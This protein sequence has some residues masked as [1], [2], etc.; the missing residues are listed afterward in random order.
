VIP[1]E[2]S[3]GTLDDHIM[4]EEKPL[5]DRFDEKGSDDNSSLQ[6]EKYVPQVEE[7]KKV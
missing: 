7:E 2:L 4:I 6:M 5:V 1:S 3:P